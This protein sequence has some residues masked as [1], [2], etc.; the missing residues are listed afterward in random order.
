MNIEPLAKAVEGLGKVLDQ[1]RQESGHIEVRIS[2]TERI[3]K[4]D[5]DIDI[6]WYAKGEYQ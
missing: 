5:L 6:R 2:S 3:G 4:K 1:Y